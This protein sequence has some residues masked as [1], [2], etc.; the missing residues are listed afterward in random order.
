MM[1]S[2]F[3]AQLSWILVVLLL[4]PVLVNS[5]GSPFQPRPRD[6]CEVVDLIFILDRSWSLRSPE[7]FQKELSFVADVVSV[8]DFSKSRVSVITFSDDADLNI[9]FN[10]YRTLSSFQNAVRTLPWVGGNTYTHKA[11]EMML[12]EYKNHIQTRAGI[13]T[14]GV[15][16]TDGGSTDPYKLEDVVKVVHNDRIEMYAIGVGDEVNQQEL[17]MLATGFDHVYLLNDLNSLSTIQ[18]KLV[19]RFCRG[20]P[21]PTQAPPSDFTDC[22]KPVDLVFVLDSSWSLMAATNFLKELK[23]VTE[24][25]NALSDNMGQSRISVITFSD[26]AEMSIPLTMFTSKRDFVNKVLNLPWVGGN[27][28]TDKALEMMY[29]QFDSIR[30]PGRRSV[31][32]VITDGG[33]TNPFRTQSVIKKVKQRGITMFAIGVGM[34]INQ[35][36]LQMMASDPVSDHKFL[37][38]DL[39][40]LQMLRSTIVSRLCPGR[41]TRPP[42]CESDPADIFFIVDKSSSLQSQ[43]NFNKEL[44]FI[45]RIIDSIIVGTGRDD[46]RVGLISFST[47]ASLSFGL[48]AYTTNDAVKDALLREKFTTGDT[49]THKAFNIMLE[50][51]RN[52]ARR[53]PRVKKIGFIV[54]DGQSTDPNTLKQYIEQVKATNIEMYAVGCCEKSGAGDFDSEELNMMA[55]KPSNVFHVD[56]LDDLRTI[57]VELNL[58]RCRN[59]K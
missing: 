54:T 58:K 19:G 16:I 32:V 30:V 8:L 51:F 29:K 1:N 45:A 27:T 33:S 55:S 43:E 11:I 36:E 17:E 39:D 12:G 26:D 2:T 21:A 48:S 42:I 5:Q 41:S 22:S 38:D 25:V 47:N 46:S 37:V 28:Y 15:V 49:Y 20:T 14:I 57:S 35:E 40:A 34:S 3:S 56:D 4:S 53:D 23:F 18:D 9:Q 24:V 10:E 50:Q 52:T 13:T 59:Q 31:G 6:D 44:S 7:N